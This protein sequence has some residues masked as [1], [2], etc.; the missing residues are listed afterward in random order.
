[1]ANINL[2]DEIKQFITI[3]KKGGIKIVYNSDEI[4]ARKNSENIYFEFDNYD[5]INYAKN[6]LEQK[7]DLL[8]IKFVV[9]TSKLINTVKGDIKEEYR[10][11]LNELISLRNKVNKLT[12]KMTSNKIPHNW[13]NYIQNRIKIDNPSI[14]LNCVKNHDLFLYITKNNIS[15]I[16]SY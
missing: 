9:R 6:F 13:Y 11:K 16:H 14:I 15:D 2:Y 5:L 8:N 1:M 4:N 7:K 12:G 10:E 3:L